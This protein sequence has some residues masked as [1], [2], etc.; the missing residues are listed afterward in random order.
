[1]DP[2]IAA[3]RG[4]GRGARRLRDRAAR[5]HAR[6]RPFE[7]FFA[8]QR[9]LYDAIEADGRAKLGKTDAEMLE[10]LL[11]RDARLVHDRARAAPA[12]RRLRAAREALRRWP[13]GTS[14]AWAVRTARRTASPASAVPRTSSTSFGT[15]SRTRS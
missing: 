2:A 13:R 8:S 6:Q 9:P 10:R 12:P 14:T 11:R 15:S 4:F 5:V 3:T 7:E 1:V